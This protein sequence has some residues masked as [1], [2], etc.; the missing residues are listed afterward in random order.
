MI[1]RDD[2]QTV[3]VLKQRSTLMRLLPYC[4]IFFVF[5]SVGAATAGETSG[6]AEIGIEEAIEGFGDEDETVPVRPVKPVKRPSR[7]TLSGKIDL[8]AICAIAHKAPKAGETDHR[9]LNSL[10][11]EAIFEVEAALSEKWK[12]FVSAK[13]FY[14]AAYDIN[15]RDTYTKNVLDAYGSESEFWETYLMGPLHP[16]LDIKIGRQVVVW[17][18]SDNIRITDVLNPLDNRLP[19]LVDLEALRLPVCMTK[20]D[21]YFGT[22]NLSAI[23]VHERR[24]SKTPVYGHDFFFGDAPLPKEEKPDSSFEKTEYAVALSGYFSGWDL[25]LYGAQLYDNNFHIE[26]SE[27]VRLRRKFSRVNMLG[28]ASAVALE[29]WLIKS[30]IAYFEGLEFFGLPGETRSRLDGL[31]GIE[32]NGFKQSSLSLDLAGR[33]LIDYESAL[34][35]PYDQA[36]EMEFLS[37]L[38]YSGDFFND[39]FHFTVLMGLFGETGQDGAYERIAFEYDVYDGTSITI[40]A[41]FYQSGDKYPHIGDNDRV[42]VNL[43]Y[44]F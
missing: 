41:A 42:F 37:A 14:D 33:Y 19:G 12:A 9:G 40:G 38:R 13:G 5:I 6:S 10:K 29:N 24:F 31:I 39:I 2:L 7:L 15:G 16:H 8:W 28:A 35:N 43:T 21:V 30:E 17:G 4:F 26:Q 22:L 23:A 20:A 1:F 44:H 3:A 11:T 27:P 36:R 25:A 32:F 34:N 18:K